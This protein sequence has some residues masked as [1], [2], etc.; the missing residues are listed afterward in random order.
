MNKFIQIDRLNTL[1]ARIN[2]TQAQEGFRVRRWSSLPEYPIFYSLIAL[3]DI[4]NVVECGTNAGASALSFAAGLVNTG[5]AGKVY[6]WDIDSI[7]GVD[8]G[9]NMESRIVRHL[10]PFTDSK[11]EIEN[12]G[13]LLIFIDGDHAYEAALKD[14]EHAATFIKPGDVLVVHDVF[15][16]PPVKDAVI[17]FLKGS[18]QY[19]EIPTSTGIGVVQW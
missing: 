16:H 4:D 15:K 19:I 5:K 9:T 10:E 14:L 7:N 12:R 1:M 2:E 18:K 3:Y 13:R 17:A 6:T 11:V 8:K